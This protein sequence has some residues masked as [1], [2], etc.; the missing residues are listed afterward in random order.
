LCDWYL[1][2]A[3]TVLP[4][5]ERA[6]D[7]DPS[8][9]RETRATLAF[10]LE[11][12]LR[13]LHPF[14]PYITEE[15]WHKLQLPP[16][17]PRFLAVAPYPGR[18]RLSAPVPLAA[19]SEH[20]EVSLLRSL[21]SAVRAVRTEYEVH[22]A[23]AAPVSL[24]TDNTRVRA[25]VDSEQPLLGALMKCGDGVAVHGAGAER[26]PATVTT[27][28]AA[29]GGPIDVRV[30]LRGIVTADKEQARIERELKRID[31]DLTALKK[32]LGAP[33]FE[34]RA[35]REVVIESRA[36]LENLEK[37]RASLVEARSRVGELDV[38]N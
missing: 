1:E 13:L 38:G 24:A 22:P 8:R 29:E 25:L 31:K 7:A 19:P 5:G 27:V 11:Q 35:P 9:V 4:R 14:V 28:V 12:S 15:L 33:G 17:A 10:V 23:A 2:A 6:S 37:A 32:K 3:K 36:L 16:G 26:P 34:E 21:V 20:G 18:D 30:G